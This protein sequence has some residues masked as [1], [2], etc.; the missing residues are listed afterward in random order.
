MTF[1]TL[2]LSSETLKAIAEQNY[3]TPTPIQ[4]RVIPL[5]LKNTDIFGIAQTGTGKTASYC[6]PIIDKLNQSR[7]RTRL[8]RALILAPTR[9]LAMQIRE[10]METYGRYVQLKLSVI[11][12]G[13]SAIEQERTLSKGVDVVIATPGRLLDT[14]SR[15]KVMLNAVEVLVID[16]AD[17]MLDMGFI[18]DIE[19][20]FSYVIKKHQTL[21]FSA[22]SSEPIRKLGNKFLSNPEEISI[23][24]SSQTAETIEQVQVHVTVRQKREALRHLIA[25]DNVQQAI[26]FCNRK[27]DVS[28]LCNSLKRHN[29]KAGM[30]HGDMTQGARSETLDQFKSGDIAFLVASDVAARG[31]DITDLPYVFNFDVP[32][33]AEEYVHRIGRT[34]RA[35]RSGKAFTLVSEDDLKRIGYVEKLI[36]QKITMLTLPDSFDIPETRP[37]SRQ[38][39]NT[40]MSVKV[41]DRS[42]TT[43]S[44]N[45]QTNRLQRSSH[46]QNGHANGIGGASAMQDQVN[47]NRSRPAR[48]PQVAPASVTGFG[49]EVPA[50]F[51]IS[52]PGLM[53]AEAIQPLV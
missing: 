9:E 39:T 42:E 29:F 10:S 30:I 18:P 45:N 11:I 21:L 8:P 15:G 7:A 5:I 33:N 32:I 24:P 50:F 44:T 49:N 31:L 48:K 6:L 36:A 17:R 14:L 37:K 13:E 4:E 28:I 27:R 38:R 47:Q 52:W 20:I 53:A 19:K 16:E 26:I 41:T 51:H 22:T 40:K 3:S 2:G 25:L 23:T 12:G 43:Q 34:G 1:D 46:Q 35:G